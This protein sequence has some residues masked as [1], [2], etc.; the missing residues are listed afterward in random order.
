MNQD[1]YYEEV[2]R[3]EEGVVAVVVVVVAPPPPPPNNSISIPHPLFPPP[4]S[5]IGL[6][7][8]QLAVRV[9]QAEY[10][11]IRTCGHEEISF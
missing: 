7:N 1:G 5:S 11:P 4:P 9:P 8:A 10:L 3:R 6:Q 2:R